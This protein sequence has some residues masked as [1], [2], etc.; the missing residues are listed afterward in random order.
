MESHHPYRM[1]M[2][3]NEQANLFLSKTY[4]AIGVM[5]WCSSTRM[6]EL[7]TVLNFILGKGKARVR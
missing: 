6:V 5:F 1:E 4:L 3:W 7:A 2:G